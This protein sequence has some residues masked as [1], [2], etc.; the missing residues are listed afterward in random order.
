MHSKCV[1]HK[2][3]SNHTAPNLHTQHIFKATLATNVLLIE[4]Y[5][6]SAELT[7][8]SLLPTTLHVAIGMK[9]ADTARMTNFS[10]PSSVS[11]SIWQFAVQ[12]DT[13]HA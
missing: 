5:G 1:A 7:D 12:L 11:C 8:R 4:G 6:T 2:D 3:D 13:P 10:D 9:D